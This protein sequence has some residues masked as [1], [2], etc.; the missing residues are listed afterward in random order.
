MSAATRLVAVAAMLLSVSGIVTATGTAEIGIAEGPAHP[1][2]RIKTGGPFL[3]DFVPVELIAPNTEP[4]RF[5][6]MGSAGSF[7][8]PCG[9]NTEGHRNSGNFMAAPGKVNGARHIHDYVGNVSADAFS[10]SESLAAAGTTCANGDKST[11]FWPVLRD[12]TAKGID[13]GSEGGG[14]DGNVGGILRPAGVRLQFRGNPAALVTA[15]PYD[16][17]L[18]TGDAKAATNGGAH[19]HAAW[20][21]TGFEDRTTTKYPLCPQGS[22]LVRILD[23]PS[24]WDGKNLDSAHHREHVVFPQPDGSCG[25]GKA[26]IPQLRIT[27]SFDRPVG[28]AF[29]VDGFPDQQHNPVTD[30]ADFMNLMPPAM[31]ARAVDCINSGRTC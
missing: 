24:C 14:L 13:A 26:V 28:R 9:T 21:C 10:T 11:Y 22:Q 1:P 3:K 16:L 6:P 4:A 12:T 15:M 23:F 19:A 30:H 5:N 20:T 17:A 31:M 18:M 2:S 7:T 8:S 29:A 27:L 25:A